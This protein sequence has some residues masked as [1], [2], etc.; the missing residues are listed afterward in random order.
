[1]TDSSL[2]DLSEE[3]V[4]RKPRQ[5]LA[6]Q[7]WSVEDRKVL[8]QAVLRGGIVIIT[9]FIALAWPDHGVDNLAELIGV[10]ALIIAA[11]TVIIE[12]GW[13]TDDSASTFT[14]LSQAGALTVAGLLLLLWPGATITVMGRLLAVGILALG[15][16]SLV[17]GIRSTDRAK[18]NWSTIRGILLLLVGIF[19]MTFPSATATMV[20]WG[21]GIAWAFAAVTSAIALLLR[22]PRPDMYEEPVEPNRLVAD[23]LRRYEMDGEQRSAVSDKLY[24]EG[25][26]FRARLWRF[27]VLMFLSTSIAT[28]GIASDSTAVVIGAMLIAP[29]MTPIMGLSGALVMAWPVRAARSGLTV[30]GG[31]IL[32][33]GVSWTITGISPQISDT[34]LSSSQVTSRVNPTLLDLGI[35]LA[36]GAAGAFAISRPDVSDSLPGVAIAVALVPP[37]AV[38]G[39]TIQLGAWDEATGA[40]V[41]FATNFVAIILAGGFVFILTGFTPITRIKEE[42]E[43]IRLSFAGVGVLMLLIIAPL[44][45]TTRAILQDSLG[46]NEA[47]AS[48]EEW[49]ADT[50]LKVLEVSLD[51]SEVDVT[52]T[53]NEPPPPIED[54][55]ASLEASLGRDVEVE[56]T[57]I[58]SQV[59]TYDASD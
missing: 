32:A 44:A 10:T 39:T 13:R 35:A 54:L 42:G 38:V 8:A 5:P 37:L 36:A 56:V 9:A 47:Q 45:L 24:F 20:L 33:V 26:Q 7:E 48:V 41:L 46:L 51:G 19:A 16:I 52:I 58:P 17:R 23:W 21:V 1:M 31:I 28:F 2:D 34:I 3:P 40:M 14:L 27:A 25:A 4:E 30:L 6:E 53:G 55:G 43:Q 11:G 12:L 18:S 49:V 50:S 59:T 29:L 22:Q 15:T 57:L